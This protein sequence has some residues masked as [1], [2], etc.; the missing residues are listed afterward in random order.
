MTDTNAHNPGN[1]DAAGEAS[2][3][4]VTATATEPSVVAV[5]GTHAAAESA[6]KALQHNGVDMTRLSIVGKDYRTEDRPLGFYNVGD[7]MKVWGTRG[8]FWGVL[9][10]L[11]LSP[12]LFLLPVLGHV[13]VFGPVTAAI[14]SALQAGVF[15]GGASA[16]AA[17][18]YSIGIPKDSVVRYE[19]AI[20]ADKFLLIVHGTTGDAAEVERILRDAG[21]ES[22]DSHGI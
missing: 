20:R 4:T 8:A 6:V 16:I 10:G 18:L 12:A 2:A 7:R 13:I 3:A 14:V 15:T 5:F 22:V 21:A 11:L 9:F 1:S 19:T 17:A